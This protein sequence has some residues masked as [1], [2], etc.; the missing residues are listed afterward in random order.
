[1]EEKRMIAKNLINQIQ[2][3]LEG[4]SLAQEFINEMR[5]TLKAAPESIRER[6]TKSGISMPMNQKP[7]RL[8]W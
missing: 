8:R 7:A 1:M 3:T 6:L 5:Q 2:T 4:G